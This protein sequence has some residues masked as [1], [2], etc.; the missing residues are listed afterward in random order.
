MR[1][2]RVK[3]LL[4]VVAVLVLLGGCHRNRANG[5]G[6]V[7]KTETIAPANAQPAQTGTDALTQT[8]EIEDSR[9]EEDGG[10]TSPATDTTTTAATTSAKPTKAHPKKKHK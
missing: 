6:S 5:A 9:S 8:T 1:E 7:T 10:V 2:V 3:R 4:I